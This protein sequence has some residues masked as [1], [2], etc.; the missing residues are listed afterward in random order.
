[1]LLLQQ[2]LARAADEAAIE[3]E[4]TTPAE[5]R[6]AKGVWTVM[7]AAEASMLKTIKNKDFQKYL[8]VGNPKHGEGFFEEVFSFILAYMIQVFYQSFFQFNLFFVSSPLQ[9]NYHFSHYRTTEMTIERLQK[10]ATSNV[11]PR[12]KSRWLH[13]WNS[14][15]YIRSAFRFPS[16][17][18]KDNTLD[19]FLN[20]ASFWAQVIH[21]LR[22]S[23]VA[24]FL[25]IVF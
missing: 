3:Y 10:I 4:R 16:A 15:P 20:R 22:F 25:F 12:F 19:L 21:T 14:P 24:F 1:M 7:N 6:S 8:S 2:D 13:H 17:R 11:E 23:I 5:V 18:F 9:I